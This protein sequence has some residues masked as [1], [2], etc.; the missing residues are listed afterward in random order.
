MG[1]WQLYEQSVIGKV[2]DESCE[3]VLVIREGLYAVIDGATDKSGL[4]YRWGELTVTS[5]R[6]A[7]EVVAA[8]LRRVDLDLTPAEII[9]L[10]SAALDH[11]LSEQYPDLN[12]AHRPTAQVAA[13][14][15]VREELFA[16]GDSQ[17]VF[18]R[19]TQYL[20]Y[21]GVKAIDHVAADMRAATIAALDAVS[22]FDPN[23]DAGR[24]A[25]LP[26]L[27]IQANL[28]NS[29]GEFGYP[30]LNGTSVPDELIWSASV[31]DATHIILASD[32]YPDILRDRTF[33]LRG[34][35]TNLRYLLM[36]D[37]HCVRELRSTKGLSAGQSSFDDRAWISLRR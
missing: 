25:I 19:D 2:D 20:G 32:G 29:S 33:D 9:D 5:G 16:V 24:R 12:P 6:F 21:N 23:D 35:E 1:A 15:A 31:S 36:I 11:E 10:L 37:P 27:E 14:N 3:D 22:Q 4:R 8:A 17:I 7:A 34:A 30:V 18:G 28:A 26:L 13:F